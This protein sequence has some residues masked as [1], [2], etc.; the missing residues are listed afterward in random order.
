ME[1]TLITGVTMAACT[2]LAQLVT[3]FRERR[4][5]KWDIEDRKAKAIALA[6]EL[7]RQNDALAHANSRRTGEVLDEIQRNTNI[8]SLAFSEANG[9]NRK[10]LA[11]NTRM[12][13]LVDIFTA[14]P[15]KSVD[16]PSPKC[17]ASEE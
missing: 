4:A 10:I 1:N 13:K 7:K 5:R 15:C 6:E 17:E 11:L 3:W 12:D 16:K 2:V 9:T 14:L 8:S